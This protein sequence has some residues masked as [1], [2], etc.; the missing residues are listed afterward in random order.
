MQ[1]L[2][3]THSVAGVQVS[4]LLPL[5][6]IPFGLA[7]FLVITNWQILDPRN[8]AWLHD[9][10]PQSFYLAWATFK[11]S[12]WSIPP[13]L[14]PNYGLELATSIF[15]VDI[16][17]LMALALKPFVGQSTEPFQYFGFWIL[18]SFLLQGVFAWMLA[19]AAGLSTAACAL[20]SILFLFLPSWLWRLHGHFALFA[21]WVIL[22][23]LYLYLTSS[24]FSLRWVLLLSITALIQ[25]YL[26]LMIAVIWLADIVR[27][28]LSQTVRLNQL[29]VES[30]LGV[31]GAAA[32]LWLAGGFVMES[33][34]SSGG[35]GQYR[36]NLSS[37]LNP[38]GW[39]YALP[40]I[41]QPTV[42]EG[43]GFQYLGL[44]V[45]FL[46]LLSIR[47][48]IEG[49]A[50]GALSR[51]FLPLFVCCIGLTLYAASN[52][53]A[54]G[55]TEILHIQLPDWLMAATNTF[56]SSGRM[57]WPVY[58]CILLGI[59]WLVWRWYTKPIALLLLFTATLIQIADTRA[60]W[61]M[62][63]ERYQKAGPTWP[64]P[65]VSPFWNL[66]AAKYKKVRGIPPENG[67]RWW[68]VVSPWAVQNGMG[69]DIVYF[70]RVDTKKLEKLRAADRQVVN[71]GRLASDTLYILDDAAR[72]SVLPHVGN[73]D[74]MAT[75]D[76]LHVLAPG[77][78]SLYPSP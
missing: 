11:N 69:T 33:G 17:P 66:A 43:E 58:Y 61:Q 59:V 38:L 9:G 29:L 63:Q 25:P 16:V 4:Q 31:G 28:R 77:G 75:I 49:D 24:G 56:R 51:R 78:A 73:E 76:G 47:A 7:A 14:N 67:G 27:R 5:L 46:F 64:S 2:S 20:V 15:Y 40:I 19:R 13:G 36:M 26:L 23:G 54:I 22:A 21:H 39:S 48:I 1:R 18:V 41:P 45:L 8:I 53:V 74:L 10:D 68:S 55:M 32:G 62:L 42:E 12:A 30:L 57:F 65:L 60:G 6:A 44:G 72:G 52:R 37:L 34:V 35:Y 70:S 71:E 3:K 50:S